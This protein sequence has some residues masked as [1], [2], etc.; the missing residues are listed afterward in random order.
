MISKWLS[1]KEA[2]I[3]ANVS[4]AQIKRHMKEG[5][6]MS[7]TFRG[8][9]KI[10]IEPVPRR[11]QVLPNTAAILQPI[12]EIHRHENEPIQAASA[13]TLLH[14]AL[15]RAKRSARRY[16]WANCA[17]CVLAVGCLGL[18]TFAVLNSQ[19][20]I[21]THKNRTFVVT[22]ELAN[23]AIERD[24]ASQELAEVSS[25]LAESAPSV[26]KVQEM[27]AEVD[28]SYQEAIT[29]KARLVIL[30]TNLDQ[31]EQRHDDD[32]KQ[33]KDLEAELTVAQARIHILEKPL[34]ASVEKPGTQPLVQAVANTP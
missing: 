33:A 10:F 6:L 28:S 1:I 20:R 14:K 32:L 29:S 16:Q 23:V 24:M 4:K 27:I 9:K 34:T 13:R 30:V 31:M 19:S 18:A 2:A 5:R 26:A 12:H 3:Y 21:E 17:L 8:R 22:H 25:K 15:D 7:M 11:G